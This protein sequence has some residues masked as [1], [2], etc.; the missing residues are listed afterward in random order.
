MPIKKIHVRFIRLYKEIKRKIKY[1]FD[2]YLKEI[3][4]QTIW[5]K[6]KNK[7]ETIS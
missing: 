2:S 6:I 5:A 7:L 4:K 1:L 3:H